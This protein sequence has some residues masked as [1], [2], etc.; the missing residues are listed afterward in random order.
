MMCRCAQEFTL[1]NHGHEAQGYFVAVKDFVELF[2]FQG[3]MI[4]QPTPLTRTEHTRFSQFSCET[5]SLY[6]NFNHLAVD[7][8]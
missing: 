1:T 2:C 5:G 7:L 3:G 8:T 4:V 6:Q